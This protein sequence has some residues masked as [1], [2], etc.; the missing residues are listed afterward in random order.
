M[1][2]ME[3]QLNAMH[4]LKDEFMAHEKGEYVKPQ[5]VKVEILIYN[6]LGQKVKTLLSKRQEA[7]THKIVWNATNDV[8]QNVGSGF[9]IYLVK[10][11][12]YRAVKKMLLLR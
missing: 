12:N 1:S 6:I 7:G 9:Y 5:P 10:A 3:R 8:G 4:A 2:D 11:G